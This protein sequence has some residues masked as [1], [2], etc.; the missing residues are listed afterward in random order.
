MGIITEYEGTD[1][2]LI[3]RAL[4]NDA[5]AFEKLFL[6]HKDAILGMCLKRGRSLSDANDLLQETFVKV[7]LNLHRYNSDFTFGQWV[8]VIARNTLIDQTRKQRENF[9]FLDQEH[10]GG[11]KMTLPANTPTPEEDLILSQNIREFNIQMGRLQPKYRRILEMRY[12][13]EY[14]YEEIAERLALPIGTVKTQIRRA[15]ECFFRMVCK[16]D[17]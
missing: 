11:V 2:E 9:V 14:S 1:Q 8:T 3:D 6:R 16:E 12:F 13:Q 10:A 17:F 15:K 4:G 5:A 7:Y